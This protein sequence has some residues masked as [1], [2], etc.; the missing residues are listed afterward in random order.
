MLPIVKIETT[1]Q[2]CIEM[3]LHFSSWRLQYHVRMF[4]SPE[5]DGGDDGAFSFHVR[6]LQLAMG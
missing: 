3:E 6:L 2:V 5:F 4:S 1:I